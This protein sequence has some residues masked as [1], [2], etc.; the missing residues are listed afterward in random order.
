MSGDC[1]GALDDADMTSY[2]TSF[3]IQGDL[4]NQIKGPTDGGEHSLMVGP[5][6]AGTNMT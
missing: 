5:L 6:L 2:L 4:F 1:L 3:L